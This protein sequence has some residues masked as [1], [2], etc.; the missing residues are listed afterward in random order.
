[1]SPQEPRR[2]SVSSSLPKFK[3]GRR[4]IY[5]RHLY[6]NFEDSLDDLGDALPLESPDKSLRLT[7][8][9]REVNT[10]LYFFSRVKRPGVDCHYLMPYRYTYQ[11]RLKIPRYARCMT[12]SGLLIDDVKEFFGECCNVNATVEALM[13][14]K[15]VNLTVPRRRTHQMSLC[16]TSQASSEYR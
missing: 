6:R 8:S 7:L 10:V 16:C 9:R 3:Q 1:M 13:P 15:D 5:T 4:G 11:S 12:Q 2:Y 14:W